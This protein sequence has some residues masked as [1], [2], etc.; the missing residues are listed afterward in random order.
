MNCCSCFSA[1]WQVLVL[2]DEQEIPAISEDERPE[3][4]PNRVFEELKDPEN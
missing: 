4:I 1:F 3:V 2:I